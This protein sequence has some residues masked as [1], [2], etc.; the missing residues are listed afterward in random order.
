MAS[1]I[2]QGEPLLRAV[3][4]YCAARHGEQ[5]LLARADIDPVDMP[6][7]VL[8]YLALFD[9]V[10]HGP[11]FRWR[12]AGTEVVN[13]FGRDPTGRMAEEV[14]SEDYLAF[15]TALVQQASRHEVPVYS[16]AAFR[17]EGPRSMLVSRLYVPLGT[18]ETGATQILAAHDFDA[19]ARVGRL[20]A[21][22]LRDAQ[23][24]EEVTR[25]EVPY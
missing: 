7:F 22:L 5:R 19:A 14:L 2:L 1:D 8:P 18:P 6:R 15:V 3:F 17:W 24:F 20:P 9:L 21:A 23:R 25:H 16:V 11:R 12:L 4:D 13:R 10:D